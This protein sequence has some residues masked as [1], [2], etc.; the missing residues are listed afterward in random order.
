MKIRKKIIA[1]FILINLMPVFSGCGL[2]PEEAKVDDVITV[3]HYAMV[4]QG[5]V[6]VE[7][8]DLDFSETLN[9]V[10]SSQESKD[11]YLK[12]NG[13][14]QNE[15]KVFVIEGEVVKKGQLLAEAPC[16]EIEEEIA[17]YEKQI[18]SLQLAIS[19]HQDLLKLAEEAEEKRS[20]QEI[21]H[22]SKSQMQVLQL[23]IEE[24]EDKLRGYRIYADM[25]GQITYLVDLIWNE[26]DQADVFLRISSMN[27]YF[28]GSMDADGTPLSI[29]EVVT[30]E[31]SDEA[32]DL[33][34]VN[35]E[36]AEEGQLSFSFS[37]EKQFE[38]GEKTKLIL[39][40]EQAENVLYVPA[41]AVVVVEDK[42]Y[43]R[44]LAEDGFPRA[45]EISVSSLINGYYIVESGLEEGE[46]IINE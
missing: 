33:T 19:Y 18:S 11:Y 15:I 41:Q 35:I 21:I 46:E 4:K 39:S 6:K 24:A 27:G 16:E 34:V 17:G 2:F 10:Y 43:V 31:I 25:D 32:F 8:G 23:R 28:K 37:A 7:R 44:V 22:D 36:E 29:G 12:Y 9:L 14:G 3:E 38:E 13:M 26:F 45:K 40:G 30:A 5:T 42:A 1:V 20:C